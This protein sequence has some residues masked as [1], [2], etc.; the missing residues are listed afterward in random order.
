MG[1]TLHFLNLGG[2]VPDLA[3]AD[4]TV[5]VTI[6]RG[7]VG[8]SEER[9]SIFEVFE[10]EIDDFSGGTEVEGDTVVAW[11]KAVVTE[12]SADSSA[13]GDFANIEGETLVIA[14]NGTELVGA[15]GQVG[16][17]DVFQDI[18]GR[19]IVDVLGSVDDRGALEE[20]FEI[21]GGFAVGM[22]VDFSS[23]N[24]AG[25]VID[26]CF[27]RTIGVTEQGEVDGNVVVGVADEDGF[28]K[29]TPL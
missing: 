29:N 11:H 26:S 15:A 27:R 22:I 17:K 23:S 12:A 10:L 20:S 13:G 2:Q 7:V 4:R 24:K 8:D 14:V 6:S 16:K 19:S 3:I 5:L 18:A 25:T 9:G 1:L 28:H 21:L